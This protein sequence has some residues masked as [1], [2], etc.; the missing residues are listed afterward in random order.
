MAKI[1]YLI[2]CLNRSG[3]TERVVSLKANWLV[4]HGYEVTI[5]TTIEKEICSFYPLSEK[6][7]LYAL[8]IDNLA[9][10]RKQQSRKDA[11]SSLKNIFISFRRQLVAEKEIVG[12]YKRKSM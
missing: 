2:E 12:I 7:K 5:L 8:H 11:L 3:G 10:V 1:I 4:E 9:D 6:I